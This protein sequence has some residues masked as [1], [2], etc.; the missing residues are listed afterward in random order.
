MVA[1]K[2][3][4]IEGAPGLCFPGNFVPVTY[5]GSGVAHKCFD[6]VRAFVPVGLQSF[7]VLVNVCIPIQFRRQAE[8]INRA[9]VAVRMQRRQGRRRAAGTVDFRRRA[10]FH[11]LPKIR[12]CGHQRRNL[13]FVALDREPPEFPVSDKHRQIPALPSGDGKIMH[14]LDIVVCRIFAAPEF[15]QVHRVRRF[16]L[17]PGVLADDLPVDVCNGPWVITVEETVIRPADLL[18]GYLREFPSDEVLKICAD[19]RCQIPRKVRKPSSFFCPQ[20]VL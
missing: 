18:T 3:L 4:A 7:D 12:F 1:C 16:N 5:P 10:R 19:L 17:K 6:A 8:Q 15:F 13:G 11:V 14:T 9:F 20:T 2:A